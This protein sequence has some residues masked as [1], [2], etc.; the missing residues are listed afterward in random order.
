MR[1]NCGFNLLIDHLYGSFYEHC[2]IDIRKECEKIEKSNIS[3]LESMAK[4]I[5]NYANKK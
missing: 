1:N 3:Y 4:N 5:G 2:K